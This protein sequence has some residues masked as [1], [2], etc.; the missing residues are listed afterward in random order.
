MACTYITKALQAG[1][2]VILPA[3]AEIIRVSDTTAITSSDC[4]LN[5]TNLET[6]KTY[7][8]I[9]AG[10]QDASGGRQ[11]YETEGPDYN[12]YIYGIIVNNVYH[13]FSS[14]LGNMRYDTDLQSRFNSTPFNG[15]IYDASRTYFNWDSDRDRGEGAKY[16]FKTIPSIGDNM[17]IIC[18]TFFLSS[19]FGDLE[20]ATAEYR[21]KPYQV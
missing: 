5:L 7:E 14:R 19:E 3:G 9:W 2:Q 4:E 8:F 6:P 10:A 15:V 18:R 17:E 1:E 11:V 13:E 21:I 16:Q 12:N 20:N